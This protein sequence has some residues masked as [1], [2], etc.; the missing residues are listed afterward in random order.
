MVWDSV[1]TTYFDGSDTLQVY[2]LR[3]RVTRL[4]QSRGSLEKYYNDLQ[5]SWREIDFRHP[6]PME[7]AADIQR[8]NTLLQEERVY[9]FLDGL[10]DRLDKI[11]ADVLQMHPFPTI[12][13]AY[14]H[15]RREAI[16]QRVMITD[17]NIETPRAVLASRGVKTEQPTPSSTGSLPLSNEKSGTSSKSQTSF[18]GTKCSHCGNLKHTR[19]DCFKLHGYPDWWHELQARKRQDKA[20][21]SGKAA[22]VTTESQLSFIPQGDVHLSDSGNNLP[23]KTIDNNAWI[24]DSGAIDHMTYDAID[25]SKTSPPRRTTIVNANGAISQVTGAGAVTLSP[26]ISLKNTL[27]VPSLSYK[28]LSDILTKEIIGRDIQPHD[29][30]CNTCILAKSHRTIYP[31]SMNKSRVPFA[32]ICSD[33]WGPSLVTTVSGFRWF[34]IFVDDCT[35]MTWLYLLKHKDEVLTVFQSFHMMVK[36]QFTSQIQVLRSDNGGE[37]MNQRF[38]DYFRIHGLLHETSCP[39]TPQQN[40]IAE[41]KNRYI[42]ETAHALLLGAH[43]PNRHWV[44]VVAT[45]MHLLNRMPSRVLQFKTPLQVLSSHVSLPS[46][47]MIPP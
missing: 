10:D 12:E 33:V 46:V 26:A 29:F 5:G 22:T 41:R 7:C 2:D 19:E 34:V 43:V 24:L 17:N 3:R 23:N 47:L 4:R 28:L 25:F 13:Q 9:I 18:G 16:R 14:A 45:A 37:Y 42:L 11:R 40:G 32:L 8:Y 38:Q 15:V 30:Q 6:N 27:L 39:Q 21:T 35:R 44:D 31:L 20:E 36:T 1:A